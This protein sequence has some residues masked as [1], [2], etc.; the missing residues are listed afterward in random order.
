M[1][2]TPEVQAQLED[3]Q[4]RL[5]FQD[6]ALQTLQDVLA[7]QQQSM[8]RLQRQ[9]AELQERLDQGSLFDQLPAEA[10]PEVPPHY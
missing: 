8:L 9:L 7:D 3:L 10:G 6:D 1:S 5:A 2:S 4:S